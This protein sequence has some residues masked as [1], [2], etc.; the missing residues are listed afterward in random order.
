M[1]TC[2]GSYMAG[3]AVDA[4]FLGAS[5]HTDVAFRATNKAY[6]AK[7]KYIRFVALPLD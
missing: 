1:P 5:A 3:G 7:I 4:R 6:T 2:A